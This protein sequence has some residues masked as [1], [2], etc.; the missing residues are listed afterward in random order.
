MRIAAITMAY[1]ESVS[2]PI[3]VRHYSRQVGRDN[4]FVIDHGSDDETVDLIKKLNHISLPRTRFSDRKRAEFISDLSKH[5]LAYYDFLIY[6]DCDEMIVA[7][8]GRYRDLTDFA[9]QTER[10]YVTSI[11]LELAQRIDLEGPLDLSRPVLEQRRHVLFLEPMCKTHFTRVPVRWG[12]GFHMCDKHPQF[13]RLYTLHLKAM[14]KELMKARNR[15]LRS[16]DRDPNMGSHQLVGD[17]EVDERFSRMCKLGI[18]DD[19]DFSADIAMFMERLE[20]FHN[21]TV[22][23]REK[24]RGAR[25]VRLPEAFRSLF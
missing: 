24:R 2:L 17:D 20:V 19:F 9:A 6:S 1:N 15:V 18:S 8:P 16:I 23:V 21:Q 5:L 7:D 4:L 12:G 11:G 13:D 10:D 25:F 3:W 14:D 22:G